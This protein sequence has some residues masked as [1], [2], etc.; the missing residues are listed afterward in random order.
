MFLLL[1]S[2]CSRLD[3]PWR[4]CVGKQTPAVPENAAPQRRLVGQVLFPA[5]RAAQPPEHEDLLGSSHVSQLSWHMSF[6]QPSARAQQC[7]PCLQLNVESGFRYIFEHSSACGNIVNV[8]PVS[9]SFSV[10][11]LRIWLSRSTSKTHALDDD[12]TLLRLTAS[13]TGTTRGV[14]VSRIMGACD[15]APTLHFVEPGLNLN[16]E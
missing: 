9:L 12:E 16:A 11:R 8:S 7:H 1:L 2:C 5:A 6:S 3:H 4:R 13:Q 10:S 15:I 14:M